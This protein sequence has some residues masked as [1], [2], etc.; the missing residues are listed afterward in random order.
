MRMTRLA[1]IVTALLAVDRPA[2]AA[3]VTAKQLDGKR[4][5][6]S[7]EIDGAPRPVRGDAAEKAK[8]TVIDGRADRNAGGVDRLNDGVLP[9]SDDDP[10]ES[11]FFDAG[12]EGGRLLIDLGRPVRVKQVN[13]YSWHRGT[14][15]PQVY[16]LYGTGEKL[17][18]KLDERPKR[19]VDPATAGWTLLAKVDTRAA[20]GEG[21][22]Q[23]AASVAEGNK[24]LGTYRYLLIDALP[25][26]RRDPFG[27]TF[28]GE[29]DVIDA[30]GPAQLKPAGGAGDGPARITVDTSD[31][32]QLKAYGERIQ[33]VADEWYPLITEMLPSDGFTP[34]S[35]VTITFR[36]DYR[37]VA[38]AGGN[39]IVCSV[40]WFTDN[41]EDL[42]AIVH[43]L[44]HVVQQYPPGRHPGWLVEG[45]A[46]YVR[47]FHYEPAGNRPR[48]N[49]DRDK[50]DDSYRTSAAFLNWA[51][52]TYDK[53]LVVKL[54][55]A[56]RQRKYAPEIWKELTGKTAEELGEEW[57]QSL[58]RE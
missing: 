16:T 10:G 22:G 20:E 36:R 35:R 50:F 21:G 37:G 53:D 47:F 55:A 54:N 49:G 17:T 19:P 57:K 32:P 31:A 8:I 48:P 30:D 58:R 41:P 14:R 4:A 11:F 33:K 12:T 38:A 45:I 1:L 2:A 34:P 29:I 27:N 18:A 25:T 23:H 56:C 43:E 51:A 5:K 42:G 39:R 24:P 26:E 13:T 28:F 9:T 46:D 15:G 3:T 40:K 52:R 44:V 7:F 6:P